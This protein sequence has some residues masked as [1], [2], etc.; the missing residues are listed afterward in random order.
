V[1]VDA[2]GDDRVRLSASMNADGLVVLLDA[3][4]P[5]WS[6]TVDGA[7]VPILRAD[8]VFRAVP[9]P[10]GRHEITFEYRP[11]S[12]RKGAAF[13]AAALALLLGLLVIE[14]F[15][16]ARRC[17]LPTPFAAPMVTVACPR[18]SSKSFLHAS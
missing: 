1:R 9:V 14:A 11:A 18:T 15:F 16:R 8:H 17:A 4:D 3:F 5:G 10:A 7:P 13:S 12:V 2:Y 6:A